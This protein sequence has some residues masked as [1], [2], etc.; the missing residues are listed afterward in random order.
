VSEF[1]SPIYTAEPF[2]S[3]RADGLNLNLAMVQG[4]KYGLEQFGQAGVVKAIDLCNRMGE[5]IRDIA[6]KTIGD[7]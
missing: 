1:K 6:G 3:A 4:Q 5:T 2:H 7:E